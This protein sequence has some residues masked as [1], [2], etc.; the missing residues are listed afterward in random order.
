MQS[1]DPYD[2]MYAN[3]FL[4]SF[5]KVADLRWV[6][7]VKPK[8]ETGPGDHVKNLTLLFVSK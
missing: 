7:D 5:S 8:A 2:F 6:K 1:G 3:D 4:S